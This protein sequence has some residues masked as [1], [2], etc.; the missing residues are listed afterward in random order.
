MKHRQNNDSIRV[1]AIVNA[2]EKPGIN[3]L[4]NVVFDNCKMTWMFTGLG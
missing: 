2:I 3:R 4:S 1:F